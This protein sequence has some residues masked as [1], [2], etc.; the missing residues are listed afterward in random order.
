M[1]ALWSQELHSA[2]AV[3][4]RHDSPAKT[5]GRCVHLQFRG[6]CALVRARLGTERAVERDND[7]INS[8][9]ADVGDI[10]L[11]HNAPAFLVRDKLS[12]S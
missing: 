4:Y 9:L 1:V 8:L 5:S 6:N 10:E 7:E 12:A 3:P 11:G 2:A